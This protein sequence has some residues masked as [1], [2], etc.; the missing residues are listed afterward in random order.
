MDQNNSWWNVTKKR[1][2]HNDSLHKE[3]R[4]SKA[5]IGQPMIQLSYTSSDLSATQVL[6]M[7]CII[8]QN[9]KENGCGL[10]I[11]GERPVLV[12]KVNE[13]GTAHKAGVHEGDRIIKVNG[14][15]VQEA[16]HFS[17]VKLIKEN[18]SYVALT[19]LGPATKDEAEQ[20]KSNDANDQLAKMQK[21]HQDGIKELLQNTR[22]EIENVNKL[23]QRIKNEYAKT[24]DEKLLVDLK[25]TQDCKQDL[26]KKLWR[27]KKEAAKTPAKVQRKNQKHVTDID[28][29]IGFDEH[30]SF[31]LLKNKKGISSSAIDLRQ[32]SNVEGISTNRTMNG[33][34]GKRGSSDNIVNT[35]DTSAPE[36]N[37]LLES[38]SMNFPEQN[39][40]I[41]NFEDDELIEEG[42]ADHGPY[43]EIEVLKKKPAHFAVFINYV[44]SE[45]DKSGL[46]LMLTVDTYKNISSTKDL[47][48][49]ASEIYKYFFSAEAIFK[50][51]V[52]VAI[53][54]S[55][56]KLLQSKN[57]SEEALK[58]MFDPS[59]QICTDVIR[60]QLSNFRSV[61]EKGLAHMYGD[62]YLPQHKLDTIMKAV[63]EITNKKLNS[64]LIE[65]DNTHKMLK[66]AP[67]NGKSPEAIKIE[68]E[69]I[70][71]IQDVIKTYAEINGYKKKK[72]VD[73]IQSIFTRGPKP[74]VNEKLR[75]FPATSS[76][77][78]SGSEDRKKKFFTNTR[79][80]SVCD[81]LI[82]SSSSLL[83][84][85]K[86]QI[87]TSA[88]DIQS[89]TQ[90]DQSFSKATMDSNR[91]L[92]RGGSFRGRGEGK[93]L[94]GKT[95]HSKSDPDPD[96][97]KKAVQ[98]SNSLVSETDGACMSISQNIIPTLEGDP[99][100]ELP[101]PSPWHQRVNKNLLKKL[102]KQEVNKQSNINELIDT[103][104]QHF[105][106]LVM[107]NKL[108]YEPL[109]RSNIV[110]EKELFDLFSTLPELVTFHK[111]LNHNFQAVKKRD[112]NIVSSV[113]VPMLDLLDSG[114]GEDF[115]KQ[116]AKFCANQKN[117]LRTI[118]KLKTENKKFSEFLEQTH[119]KNLVTLGRLQLQDWIPAQFQRLTKYP[120][121]IKGIIKCYKTS[122]DQSSEEYIGLLKLK[123]ITT[124]NLLF[125]DDFIRKTDNRYDLEKVQL[126]LDRSPLTMN[127]NVNI[128]GSLIHTYKDIDLLAEDSIYQGYLK[129]V[130]GI[131]KQDA[132]DVFVV[133]YKDLI[134]LIEINAN[135][136]PLLNVLPQKSLSQGVGIPFIT[137]SDAVIRPTATDKRA[138][139]MLAN[140]NMYQMLASTQK[141]RNEW[142]EVLNKA[143]SKA[144]KSKPNA[145]SSEY[146]SA[147]PQL[148]TTSEDLNLTVE[149]SI[150]QS[151]EQTLELEERLKPNIDLI[152]ENILNEPTI[153]H[154]TS[155]YIREENRIRN[156]M[157]RLL[158]EKRKLIAEMANLDL[159]NLDTV[160][161]LSQNDTE[162]DNKTIMLNMILNM[163]NLE[164]L[165]NN[166]TTADN[167][168]TISTSSSNI[169]PTTSNFN[170]RKNSSLPPEDYTNDDRWATPINLVTPKTLPSVVDPPVT[171]QNTEDIDQSLYERLTNK[172]RERRAF[173]SLVDVERVWNV[174][175]M[176]K[177]QL[178]VLLERE[179]NRNTRD[180]D[181]TIENAVV[182]IENDSPPPTYEEV[183][184]EHSEE[185]GI[186]NLSS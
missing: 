132:Y 78:E 19:L 111:R 59:V 66:N 148:L 172:N 110:N 38:K 89:L 128:D 147:R 43:N 124:K 140:N 71:F 37:S 131:K 113:A 144:Q 149:D 77:Q 116:A 108:F 61:R 20:T 95:G 117:S 180:Q 1:Q 168:Y 72:T 98:F 86:I 32:I 88:T 17:V 170:S 55:I 125:T 157:N 41:L 176:M 84:P 63:D 12:E 139:F 70:S 85:D 60:H 51:N 150:G 123:E 164:S 18:S 126:N 54:E 102:S 30:R 65:K 67:E 64:L 11:I 45:V 167:I 69:K 76:S 121:M 158:Q 26:E 112:G 163:D 142:V 118:T 137:M 186:C 31:S 174:I 130:I 90:V 92:N 57:P 62:T 52:D 25:S 7:K 122:A 28:E 33:R 49:K 171:T 135:K 141:S 9:D 16:D 80:D 169:H 165:V 22:E 104:M 120:L 48:K 96:S 155:H 10:V 2:H 136:Q 109:Q 107:I 134:V 159:E 103:E 115:K 161:E 91:K 58:F 160:F 129:Y 81:A 36:L 68:L 8:L 34:S 97:V 106:N 182:D 166:S 100:Y 154:T 50:V 5:V 24:M 183:Q 56:N 3:H 79:S 23:Q 29:Y 47:L 35:N 44:L 75:K 185:E 119:R 179:M 53:G 82:S 99:D 87:S 133:V 156:N 175:T 146:K 42:I 14:T 6:S 162:V 127:K 73:R 94:R 184:Q 46:L 83:S 105:A 153:V 173:T 114:I 151:D 39:T 13:G 74:K 4:I 177:N 15:N 93:S 40:S 27:A 178:H 21:V 143:V 101:D 145:E 152:E 138:F 181:Y